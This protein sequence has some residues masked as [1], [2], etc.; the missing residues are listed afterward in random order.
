MALISFLCSGT[1][2]FIRNTSFSS[3]MALILFSPESC[4]ILSQHLSHSFMTSIS[5][6]ALISFLHSNAI[7]FFQS[8]NFICIDFYFI[9]SWNLSYLSQHLIHSV[10]TFIS[11]IYFIQSW[12]FISFAALTSFLRSNSNS[13]L[14][15]IHFISVDFYFIPS[16]NLSYFLQFIHGIFIVSSNTK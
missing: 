10:M 2:S 15:S 13:F 6:T 1:I 11:F 14:Q 9:L 16:W 7:S 8:I 3:F 12:Q 5:F 4:F